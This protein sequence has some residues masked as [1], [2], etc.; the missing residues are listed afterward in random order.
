MKILLAPRAQAALTEQETLELARKHVSLGLGAREAHGTTHARYAV[1]DDVLVVTTHE[2][3]ELTLVFELGT[4]E[5]S[6]KTHTIRTTISVRCPRCRGAGRYWQ[7]QYW[8]QG[9][10]DCETCQTKGAITR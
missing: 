7:S 8:P 6:E 10:D 3:G 9:Y 5:I 2:Q 4:E 1:A